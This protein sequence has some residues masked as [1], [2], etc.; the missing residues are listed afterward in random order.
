MCDVASKLASWFS[1]DLG[2]HYDEFRAGFEMLC[3]AGSIDEFEQQWDLLVTRFGL[4]PDRHAALLYSCRA[5]WSPCCVRQHF[6][7]QTMT[8]EFSL[9]IDSFLKRIVAEPTCMQ[10][11]LEEVCEFIIQFQYY[12]ITAVGSLI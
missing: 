4:V 10:A 5:T 7:A 2:S 6:L 8:P 9:S 12:F 11:L 1:Q 3:R